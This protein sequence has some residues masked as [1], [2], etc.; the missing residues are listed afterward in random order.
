VETRSTKGGDLATMFK[1]ELTWPQGEM[2]RMLG[3]KIPF[4]LF[5]GGY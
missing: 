3:L 4:P 1:K 2:Y 5:T